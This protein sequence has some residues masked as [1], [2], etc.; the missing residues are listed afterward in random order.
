MLACSSLRRSTPTSAF[1]EKSAQTDLPVLPVSYIPS[2]DSTRPKLCLSVF[3]FFFICRRICAMT[4]FTATCLR[5]GTA[6]AMHAFFLCSN[7]IENNSSYNQKQD[8]CND[9]VDHA[10]LP[11]AYS[12]FI[13]LLVCMVNPTMM[14]TKTNTAASPPRA[15]PTLSDAGA[16]INVPIV[17]TR[18]PTEKPTPS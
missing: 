14:P 12:A 5:M 9:Q 16:V 8:S 10:V 2:R 13:F 18:Y 1:C 15:A 7:Q 4:A 6:N 17:Y 11:S 3:L